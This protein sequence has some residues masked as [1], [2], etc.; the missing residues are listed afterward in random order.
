ISG[1][2][3]INSKFKL[4]GY[5]AKKHFHKV[6]DVWNWGWSKN[7]GT[8][9]PK[10]LCSAVSQEKKENPSKRFIVHYMQPHAPYL[11]LQN[12]KWESYWESHKQKN[13]EKK[14][15]LPHK[16]INSWI[17]WKIVD[18]LGMERTSK[19]REVLNLP[20]LTLV[21]RALRKVGK[22]GLRKSYIENLETCLK[23]I[24]NCNEL[25][26]ENK[27]VIV[28]SDHGELLGEGKMWGHGFQK[29]LE[30][31]K[32]PWLEVHNTKVQ[33]RSKNL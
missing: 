11:N 2:P 20:P 13:S 29:R 27:E 25:N 6:E 23:S 19:I 7:L 8:V 4:R 31:V 17:W 9:L 5:K 26:S 30:L 15:R 3:W 1:N 22:D 16:K 10:K 24:A 12:L 32:V 33:V 18:L 28:T 14:P 21:T